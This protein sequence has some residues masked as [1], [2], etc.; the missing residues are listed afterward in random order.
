MKSCSAL[1]VIFQMLKW[2]KILGSLRFHFYHHLQEHLFLV[3]KICATD[4][5]E[6]LAKQ[7]S[8]P[9]FCCPSAFCKADPQ[10]LILKIQLIN[11]F[12]GDSIITQH[13]VNRGSQLESFSFTYPTVHRANHFILHFISLHTWF[14]YQIKQ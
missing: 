10:E 3:Y 2:C 1:S 5:P 12:L 9:Q 14:L 8:V 7:F 6:L 11:G 13:N 4:R